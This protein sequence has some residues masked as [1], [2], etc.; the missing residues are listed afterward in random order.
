[1]ARASLW[2]GIIALPGIFL[3]NMLG[4]PLAVAAVSLGIAALY[5]AKG[6][7]YAPD[8]RQAIGGLVCGCMAIFGIAA[9]FAFFALAR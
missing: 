4:L 6:H 1:M 3:C 7:P 5:R 8:R 2:L 9:L